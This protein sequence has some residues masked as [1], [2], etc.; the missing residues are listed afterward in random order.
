MLCVVQPSA[1]PRS[2][3]IAV[4]GAQHSA[5]VSPV[6]ECKIEVCRPTPELPDTCGDGPDYE[7]TLIEMAGRT[8]RARR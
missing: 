2:A 4:A 7:K 3:L 1:V 5:E 8:L 6:L